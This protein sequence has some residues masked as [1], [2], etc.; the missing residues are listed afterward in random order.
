MTRL[1]E[2]HSTTQV[3][4]SSVPKHD[5]DLPAADAGRLGGDDPLQRVEPDDV[6]ERHPASE[7]DGEHRR[8]GRPVHRSG[9][10]CRSARSGCPRPRPRRRSP[11]AARDRTSSGRAT[12]RAAAAGRRCARRRRRSATSLNDSTEIS[13]HSGWSATRCRPPLPG[14]RRRT[15]AAGSAPPRSPATA[16]RRTR[17]PVGLC[18]ATAG[19]GRRR[20]RDGEGRRGPLR[21]V[22]DAPRSLIECPPPEPWLGHRDPRSGERRQRWRVQQSATGLSTLSPRRTSAQSGRTGARTPRRGWRRR[23]CA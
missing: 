15:G 7:V 23:R 6:A 8:A 12:D 10:P 18:W 1:R 21:C 22:A 13:G 17:W 19:S 2:L 11:G 9:A 4:V 3:A 16:T 20:D 5:A 14:C